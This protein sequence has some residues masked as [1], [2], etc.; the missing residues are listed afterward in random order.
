MQ[1]CCQGIVSDQAI[2]GEHGL[3]LVLFIEKNEKSVIL[4]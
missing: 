1:W 4:F 3:A 2:W